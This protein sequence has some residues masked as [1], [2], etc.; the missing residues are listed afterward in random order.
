MITKMHVK[1]F[2]VFEDETFEFGRN[3][4]VIVGVNG[5]GKTHLLKLAYLFARLGWEAHSDGQYRGGSPPAERPWEEVFAVRASDDLRG[6]FMARSERELTRWGAAVAE[7]CAW[8][9]A[10]GIGFALRSGGTVETMIHSDFS[11]P[12]PNAWLDGETVLVPASDV[13]SRDPGLRPVLKR[14]AVRE[15][16]TTEALLDIVQGAPLKREHVRPELRQ[17][18]TEMHAR[19]GGKP[20]VDPDGNVFIVTDEGHR[21]AASMAAQGHLRLATIALLL[22]RLTLDAGSVICWDEPEANMNPALMTAAC[23]AI[24]DFARAGI[25]MFVATHSL[26]M[27]REL[28]MLT[29]S[30]VYE[31]LDT[32]YVGLHRTDS[33]VHVT[34]GRE[35]V[36]LGELAMLDEELRQS[37]RY[38]DLENGR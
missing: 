22:T 7:V 16:Q 21:V 34:Q 12:P 4:N 17:I 8:A 37:D 33:G 28:H 23:K 1:N 15:E 29:K 10:D 30:P 19:M 2:T 32:R 26:F 35:D 36:D 31:G 18:V 38:M 20:E 14:Y 5:T 25:Q 3:L 13:L 6:L 9:E 11:Y 27:L 24:L